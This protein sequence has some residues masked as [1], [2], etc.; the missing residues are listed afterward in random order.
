[1]KLECHLALTGEMIWAMV[2]L[3]VAEGECDPEE[4]VKRL[5]E[6]VVGMTE[7]RENGSDEVEMRQGEEDDERRK[8]PLEVPLESERN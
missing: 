6:P 3:V 5:R 8:R 4:V 2:E 7:R 1:M